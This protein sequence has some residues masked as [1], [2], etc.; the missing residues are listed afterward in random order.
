[1]RIGL[2]AVSMVMLLSGGVAVQSAM[3]ISTS[4]TAAVSQPPMAYGPDGGE[5]YGSLPFAADRKAPTRLAMR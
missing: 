1:M 4:A 2:L 5:K 3:A